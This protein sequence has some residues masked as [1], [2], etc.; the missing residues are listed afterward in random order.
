MFTG[1][2]TDFC[3]LRA[4]DESLFKETM[5][6]KGV[7]YKPFAVATQVVNGTNYKFLCN[8]TAVTNPPR[9]FLAQVIIYAPLEGQAVITHISELN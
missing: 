1:G 3:A 2:W 6:L 8:A 7:D 5:T 9:R 4:E